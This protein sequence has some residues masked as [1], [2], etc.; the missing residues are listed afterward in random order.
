MIMAAFALA[1]VASDVTGTWSGPIQITAPDGRVHDD[2]I[3]LILKQDAG[4]LTGTFGPDAD[5]QLPIEKGAVDGNK[6]SMQ[7]AMPNGEVK[8]ELT[9][10]GDHLKGEVTIAAGG[11][12]ARA[13]VDATKA[14]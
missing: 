3:H 10:E 7:A 2:T 6:V 1:A 14:K 8:F 5:R 12:T 13:K 11:Q 9:M 4:K